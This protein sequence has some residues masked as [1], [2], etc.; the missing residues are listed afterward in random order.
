M[1]RIFPST[2]ALQTTKPQATLNAAADRPGIAV[3]YLP[4]R[5][6]S[7]VDREHTRSLDGIV[8]A[9]LHWI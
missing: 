1:R 5:F 4:G 8:G 9:H 6:N 7:H 3:N 2:R